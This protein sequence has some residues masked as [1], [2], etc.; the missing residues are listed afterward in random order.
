MQYVCMFMSKTNASETFKNQICLATECEEITVTVWNYAKDVYGP[1]AP[2]KDC[3]PANQS[4]QQS[5]SLSA[6]TTSCMAKWANKLAAAT[7][8][9]WEHITGVTNLCLEYSFKKMARCYIKLSETTFYTFHP[10]YFKTLLVLYSVFIGMTMTLTKVIFQHD[11]FTFTKVRLSGTFTTLQ[12]A[13]EP[14]HQ[15]KV[16]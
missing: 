5:H 8:S 16:P 15:R 2:V 10:R 4:K 11:I 9:L 6:P 3:H 7:V 13:V 14:A 12:C 1:S